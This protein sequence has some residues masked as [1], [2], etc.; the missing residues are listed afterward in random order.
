MSAL[1]LL[2]AQA[3]HA[4][5][6][7]DFI[8]DYVKQGL[9]ILDN[10]ALPHAEK[11]KL[12]QALLEPITDMRRI[13]LYTLGAKAQNAP[14]DQ[15]EA[16]VKAFHDLEFSLYERE[17]W[18]VQQLKVEAS[19][20]R[21][22]DDTV[23]QAFQLDSTGHRSVNA[24]EIDFRVLN[25]SDKPIFADL[26]V[27]GAWIAVNQRIQYEEF[28]AQ[29][30]NTLPKLIDKLRNRTSKM[31]DYLAAGEEPVRKVRKVRSY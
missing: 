23:V 5:K 12:F 17:L 24:D 21:A 15:I 30:G 28:L 13:A 19:V 20:E 2:C 26:C 22:K 31:N 6:A 9:T 1:F 16:F 7:E 18:R 4:S 29:R 8:Q 3:A 27:R 10:P 14:S 25:A 11:H